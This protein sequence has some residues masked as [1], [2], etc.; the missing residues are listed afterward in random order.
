MSQ[1]ESLFVRAQQ[2]IL[3]SFTLANLRELIFTHLDKD[4]DHITLGAGLHER[5]F[6]L[7]R[8]A[9]HEGWAQALLDALAAERPNRPE[10]AALANE[11]RGGA[12]LTPPVAS[13]DST[14]VRPVPLQRPR[15]AEHFTGRAA[16]LDKLMADLQPG[17]VVTLCGPG[18]MGKSSLA[19][20]AVRLLAP[21]HDPPDRFPDGIIL[22]QFYQQPQAAQAFE[23]IARA[24]GVDPRPSPQETARQA[25]AN[26]RALLILD[27]TEAAT[28]ENL[29]SVLGV[30]GGCGVLIT[31]RRHSDAPGDYADITP[32]PDAES[33]ALLRALAGP[34]AADEGVANA[35]IHLL[36]GLPLALYLAGRYLSRRK[37]DA[38]V[39]LHW[40]RT[41]GLAAVAYDKRPRKS[42]PLQIALSL[43]Q[44]SDAARAAF[45]ITGVLALAP[46]DAD[47]V[48]AGLEIEPAVFHRALGDLVEY[49]LL[50]RPDAHY[51]VTHALA[52]TY[53]R[54]HAAP[55]AAT[56]GRLALFYAALA[57]SASEQGLA[58]FAFLD[59]QRAHLV[60][61]QAAALAAQQW[62]AVRQIVRGANDYLNLKGYWTE[63]R[64]MLQAGLDAARAAVD[65]YDEG[66]FSGE[67]G[68]AYAA[69][70]E[71]R[72]AIE[73]Y[74]QQLVITREIGDRR[75]E[76]AA[77]GNLG[78]AYAALGETRRAIELYEQQL[79]ITR[80]IGDRRGEAFACW[81]LG[82]AYEKEGDLAR[83]VANMQVCVDYEQ[84][85]GHPDAAADAQRL[86]DLKQR[87]G[88]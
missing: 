22:H 25:L 28:A 21:S 30:A 2:A 37:Q 78:L 58:G 26:R 41:E 47:L 51:Q 40:L 61:V 46:F 36:G 82:L 62:D 50:L 53:A 10:L 75:G 80:E 6:D 59:R 19:A 81:N 7:L 31:T 79:V 71:T 1:S 43:D 38:G 56:I 66:A 45:G 32:L 68:N 16:E 83:A 33:L 76:G 60:A 77:L 9:G 3:Q 24:Y 44:V 15:P 72:R 42:V 23:T 73:L 67:L 4:L 29:D 18:G 5:V 85:I 86:A 13:A 17:K 49:G 65:R 48:A 87:A 52:H 11:L 57:Q 14:G 55:P 64:S 74:E 70:G 27:G 8:R 84:E 69:L 35:V 12:P 20:E 63:R 54:A 34:Y 88:M 39:Y